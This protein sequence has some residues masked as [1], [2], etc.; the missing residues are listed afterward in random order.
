MPCTEILWIRNCIHRTVILYFYLE[1]IFK[2]VS[3]KVLGLKLVKLDC[4]I[5]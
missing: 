3:L 1:L 5:T 2:S 4:I